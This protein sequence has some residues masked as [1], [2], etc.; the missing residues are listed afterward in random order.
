MSC[1]RRTTAAHAP[2]SVARPDATEDDTMATTDTPTLPTAIPHGR[3]EDVLGLLTGV[4]LVAVGMS[5]LRAAGLVTGGI[6]G[7]ALLLG[8][9]VDVPLGVLFF[10]LNVP[11][12][13]LAAHRSGWS[14]TLRSAATVGL[15]SLGTALTA[16][17]LDVASVD[18]WFAAVVGNLL[19]GTGLLVVFRHRSSV[20]GFSIVAVLLQE[21]AGIRAGHVL[22]A[23]DTLV[24]L[25][26]F[27]V[28]PPL[29]VLVSA[30]GAVLLSLVVTFN[31]RPGRYTGF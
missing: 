25:A 1:A 24:V 10:A 17:H 30:G 2:G 15:V 28:A 7:A 4:V 14:F 20:G 9:A 21:R 16:A 27:A 31:H 11:F 3:A 6:A 26:A 29:D 13:A 19:C 5:L 23:L 8:H 22:M 18:P 12:F